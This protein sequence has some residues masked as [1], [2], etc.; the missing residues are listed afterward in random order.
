MDLWSLHLKDAAIRNPLFSSAI[1]IPDKSISGKLGALEIRF[2]N[3]KF[4]A[5]GY[6]SLVVRATSKKSND[7]SSS[8]GKSLLTLLFDYLIWKAIFLEFDEELWN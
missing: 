4:S 2:L 6:R 7:D 5:S 3:R 8:S 1:S